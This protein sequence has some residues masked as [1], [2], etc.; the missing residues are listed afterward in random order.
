MT[1]D[2]RE[3]GGMLAGEEAFWSMARKEFKRVGRG[4]YSKR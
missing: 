1:T 4:G 3:R 2:W